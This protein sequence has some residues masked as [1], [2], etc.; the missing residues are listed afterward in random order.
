MPL[1]SQESRKQQQGLKQQQLAETT[2]K[3]NSREAAAAAAS[4]FDNTLLLYVLLHSSCVPSP[5]RDT[6]LKPALYPN[7]KARH[8]D[9]APCCC[10]SCCCC[11]QYNGMLENKYTYVFR[12]SRSSR[13]KGVGYEYCC[14]LRVVDAFFHDTKSAQSVWQ[15]R[16]GGG[17]KPNAAR[18]RHTQLP[19]R[20]S[21]LSA[22]IV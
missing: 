10:C 16:L 11:Y 15:H 17:S 6:R 1:P 8:T 9:L 3:Q 12:L 5:G 20:A 22:V 19:F 2:T 21:I 4:N 18:P 7:L 13:S 14:V